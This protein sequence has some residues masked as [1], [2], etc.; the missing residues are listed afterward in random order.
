M[1]DE[2]RDRI[3]NVICSVKD[4]E[5]EPDQVTEEKSFRSDLDFDSLDLA[6]LVMKMEEEFESEGVEEIPQEEADQLETVA[7]V[8]DYIKGKV[9]PA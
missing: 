6:A 1:S 3:V 2:L 9:N 5:L 4:G 7:A 8:I